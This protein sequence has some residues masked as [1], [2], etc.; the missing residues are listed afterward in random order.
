M[1]GGEEGFT[2]M[3]RD[4]FFRVANAGE[5]DAGIPSAQ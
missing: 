1:A 2:E 4:D 3:A 5:V